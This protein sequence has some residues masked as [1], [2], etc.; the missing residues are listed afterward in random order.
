MITPAP[1]PRTHALPPPF[2]ESTEPFTLITQGAEALLYRT[3]F[4][5]PTTPAALK[6]R[7][8]KPWRHPT[9]DARLTRQRILAEARVLVKC[10][11]EGVAVPGVYALDW[12]AGWMMSEWIEGPTVKAA[13]RGRRVGAEGEEEELKGLMRRIGTAVG[14][15]HAIGVIHGDLTTSNMMLRRATTRDGEDQIEGGL[16]GEIVLID[17]GLATQA[18][19]EED[20]A[21]DLYVLERAFGST[22]PR[23]EGLFGEVLRA[24]GETSKSAKTTLKRLEDVRMRGRKKSMLG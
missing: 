12:E 3:T 18:V 24:Y 10:R 5:T 4:L 22:H 16:E 14:R 19:Q 1:P 15:L 13:V 21:V 17:F 6:V 9:L 20:R 8:A 2:S 11:K 23:E 7:P